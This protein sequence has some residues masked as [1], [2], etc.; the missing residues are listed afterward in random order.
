MTMNTLLLRASGWRE[1]AT[2]PTGPARAAALALA[3]LLALCAG[4]DITAAPQLVPADAAAPTQAG[5]AASRGDAAPSPAADAD[6]A[7]Y[8]I[9]PH[10]M[11]RIAVLQAPELTGQMRVSERGEISLP[12]LGFLHVG[13]LTVHELKA[14][15]EDALREKY[16]RRPDVTVQVLESQSQMVSVVGAVQRPGVH[17]IRGTSTLLEVISLAGGLAEDAG[18]SAIVLRR[19]ARADTAGAPPA[20]I[21]VN[22]KALMESRDTTLNVQVQAGDVVNVRQAAIVYVIGEVNKPGFFPMQGNNRLTVLRALALGGGLTP[23]ASKGGAVVVRTDQ[24]GARTE[25]PVDLGRILNGRDPDVVLASEDVLFVPTSG[26]RA[27]TLATIDTL[28]G[29]VRFRPW[30]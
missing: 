3:V 2:S 30:P 11:L 28:L 6:I 8:R 18:E 29:L 1:P 19:T 5:D 16:I 24:S 14:K 22:L 13:N 23:Q 7:E 15:L 9:G 27:A 10:D 12:L 17:Q 26:A 25:I 21:E 4:I 20:P